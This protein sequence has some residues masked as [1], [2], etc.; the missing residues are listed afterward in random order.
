MAKFSQIFKTFADPRSRGETRWPPRRCNFRAFDV[1]RSQSGVPEPMECGSW[2]EPRVK[3][4]QE[5]SNPRDIQAIIITNGEKYH[6]YQSLWTAE[7]GEN[8]VCKQ[9]SS[10]SRDRY[11]VIITKGE[12]TAC[13]IAGVKISARQLAVG[14]EKEDAVRLEVRK[15]CHDGPLEF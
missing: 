12:M 11:A 6:V 15:Q 13:R 14:F 5:S 9:E 1:I 7:V 10:N 3:L 8:L 4:K 2:G